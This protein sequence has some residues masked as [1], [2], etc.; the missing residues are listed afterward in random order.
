M[1]CLAHAAA[2]RKECMHS[3]SRSIC[4]EHTSIGLVLHQYVIY[5]KHLRQARFS[6]QCNKEMIYRALNLNRYIEF[7]D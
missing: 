6:K 1:V 5:A 7:H 4:N 2:S 3:Y